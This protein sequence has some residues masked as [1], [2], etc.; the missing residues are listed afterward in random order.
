MLFDYTYLLKNF[1]AGVLNTTNGQ[2][3]EFIIPVNDEI[4]G[5]KPGVFQ[6]LLSSENRFCFYIPSELTQ[7]S[8]MFIKEE[9]IKNLVRLL[10]LPNYMRVDGNYIFF[11]D[12]ADEKNKGIDLLANEFHNELKKQG[13]NDILF[14]VLQTGQP[15]SLG[16][17]KKIS[18]IP[19][20]LNEYL[21]DSNTE[22]SFETFTK[23]FT[24][25]TSFQKKWIVPVADEDNFRHKTKLI[26]K[27]ENWVALTNPL[28]A[29]LV[30]MYK[31]AKSE[32]T[33]LGSENK[34]LKFKLE[35]SAYY[36]KLIREQSYGFIEEIGILRREI[37]RLVQ[38]INDPTA[39]LPPQVLHLQQNDEYIGK[40]QTQIAAEQNRANETLE[41]YKKEYEV[42]PMWY[43]KFGQI[44]KVFK[45]KR[46]FRS[47]FK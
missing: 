35:N 3:N 5:K 15:A 6:T 12:E 30:Q 29:E 31:L 9:V 20:E 10:F 17:E 40:L 14:E 25:P 45:G 22:E 2:M 13:I 43:K 7:Y 38:Q 16:R 37:N 47:L 28:N 1:D 19:R 34:I 46:T 24:F 23:K 39:H 27:F 4:I 44:I 42:L 41:W 33:M 32:R 21:N 18:S 8:N 26:E 36:L 11:I